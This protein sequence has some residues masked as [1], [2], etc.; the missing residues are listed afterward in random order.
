[1]KLWFT[2]IAGPGSFDDLLE[3]WEPTKSQF[4]GLCV[5]Y[6]GDRDDPEACYLE[7]NKGDGL[8]VY[9]P[10]VGR[11]DQSRNV[12][13]HCGRINDGDWVMQCDTLERLNPIFIRDSIV[14]MVRSS[15]LAEQIN[16]YFY[17][18]KPL[19]FQYHESIRYVG[20]PHEGFRRDD[21]QLRAAELS[22]TW[23][24]ES[25]VRLNV[26]PIKRDKMHWVGQYARYMLLPWGSNHALHGLQH[27]G[28]VSQLFPAREAKRLEFREEMRRRGFPRTE[29]GLKA[30]LSG[31][32][33]ERLKSLVNSDKVW[34][35]W[36]RFNVLGETDLTDEHAWT[37][38]RDIA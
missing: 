21:G 8:I 13:L 3:L 9:L 38:K 25:K 12:A 36:Y 27:Q 26:R 35:D 16:C 11:H 1:M 23:P 5:T 29:A 32:L 19:A 14:P 7:S 24:D 10:Y 20:T 30:M 4:A 31:P 34:V 17:F 18:G 6:H 33:D 2:L 22:Q 15:I 28:D 37:T